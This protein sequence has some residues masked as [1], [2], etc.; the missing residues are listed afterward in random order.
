MGLN[1]ATDTLEDY[2]NSPLVPTDDPIGYWTSFASTPQTAPLT[3]MCLD[4]LSCPG[5]LVFTLP[6]YYLA[7]AH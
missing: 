4:V 2:L 3:R 7:D 5:E 1:T 6:L